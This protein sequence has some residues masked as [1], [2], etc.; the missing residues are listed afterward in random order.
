VHR[1]DVLLGIGAVIGARWPV[2]RTS[3]DKL[4][5]IGLQLYTVREAM[6]LDVQR[7]LERVAQ[8]G[9]RDVEFAG[10]FGRTPAQIRLAV[11]RVG[12][13]AP[14]AHIE[15]E[16]LESDWRRTLD[17]AAAAGHHYVVVPWIPDTART[18]ED[19]WRRL[20]DVLNRAGHAARA[21][22]VRLAYHNQLYDVQPIRDVLPIDRLAAGTDPDAL[23]FELDVYWAAKGGVD[24]LVLLERHP[25]RFT[26]VHAK[27]IGAA[28]ALEMKDVGAGTVD[29][30]AL[31]AGA[32]PAHV[33]VEHDE[34]PDALNS[35][36]TSY[37][38]LR[39][40]EF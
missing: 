21:A 10:Y 38:Y 7:T 1:R 33:F 25:G 32:R 36:R 29:W 5:R 14:S 13:R 6:A 24:P 31:L 35:V 15:Y 12:L 23:T 22:G 11:E 37:R 19:D 2:L 39:R 17:D 34:P 30:R 16:R 3:R 20:A 8:I 4:D 9:F 26:L 40:L 18:T 28:P 27:D